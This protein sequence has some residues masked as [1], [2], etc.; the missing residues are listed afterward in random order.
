MNILFAASDR[1]LLSGFRRLLGAKG[2]QVQ[3]AFD[4]TQVLAKL[5]G[6]TFDLT[7]LDESLPRI[8]RSRL[9]QALNEAKVPV[10]LLLSE[11]PRVALYDSPDLPD[12]FLCYP[13]SPEELEQR[14]E[15]V[16]AETTAPDFQVGGVAVQPSS[17]L[18]SGKLPVTAEEISFLR[19]LSAGDVPQGEEADFSARVLNKKFSC[20][21][22]SIR[23]RYRLHEGY[24]VVTANE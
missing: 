15:R 1:D 19:S 21:Q 10:I 22:D 12:S 6:E 8:S 24:R 18:L 7:V 3:T 23:I 9:L 2:H 13:F 4:G 11:H 14:I 5:S 17:R 20:L 16:L